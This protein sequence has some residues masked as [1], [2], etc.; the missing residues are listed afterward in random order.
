MFALTQSSAHLS[1]K[2]VTAAS[3]VVTMPRMG[4]ATV[5]TSPI[6]V[7]SH[8]VAAVVTP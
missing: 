7:T 5:K 2:S 8:S 3:T 4:L 6:T 1:A